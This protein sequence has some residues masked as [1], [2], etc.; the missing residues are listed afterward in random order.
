MATLTFLGAARTVTGSMF[1][2]RADSQDILIDCGLFQGAENESKNYRELPFDITKLGAIV[3]TH[4]HQDHCG[5]LPRLSSL[6]FRGKVICT[7]ATF[8]LMRIM[9]MDAAHIHEE[10]YARQKKLSGEGVREPI[11]TIDDVLEMEKNLK[12]I[13]PKYGEEISLGN[14][15][16]VFRDAGHILGS[17]FVEITLYEDGV[18]KGIVISGDIG[19]YGKP[20]L[21]DPESP[22]LKD[23]NIVLVES[24]YGDRVHK[25]IVES[26]DELRHAINETI[27]SG[28][29]IIPVF[30]LDRAQ[31]ILYILRE[32]KESG[33]LDEK[34]QIFLDSPLAINATS[35]YASHVECFDDEAREV[36]KQHRNPFIFSGVHL[37]RSVGAS[38]MLNSV[39]KG[40]IILAGSGMCTGGRVR[41][42]LL[43][44]LPDPKSAVIFVGFQA[45]G[46]TGREIIDGAKRIKI[47]DEVV[48]V[49]AKI[50]TINGFSAHADQRVLLDWLNRFRGSPELYLVHGDAE[51]MNIFSEF[52]KKEGFNVNLPE[53]GTEVKI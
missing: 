38:K 13:L 15:Q 18:K 39:R 16:F 22:K 6:G 48:E 50:Y 32:F 8:D 4:A 1:L 51:R 34:V 49:N 52:L 27:T 3:L 20:V 28:N 19:N 44:N 36:I 5:L 9:L 31:D 12:F 11:F 45:E 46:T 47:Y 35:I 42:H 53:E 30:S 29:V 7:P 33:D 21:R 2:L 17:A 24:T 10:D 25:G 43:K 37:V 23:A 41:Y 26:K 40:A 14:I